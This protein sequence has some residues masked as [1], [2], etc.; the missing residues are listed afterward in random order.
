MLQTNNS[1]KPNMTEGLKPDYISVPFS[2]FLRNLQQEN[3]AELGKAG[4][5]VWTN[6]EMVF[7]KTSV[8]PNWY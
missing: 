6:S 8:P 3:F 1:P 5:A 7:F 4:K 2:Q